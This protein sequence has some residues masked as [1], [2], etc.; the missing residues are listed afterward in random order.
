MSNKCEYFFNMAGWV[1]FLICSLFYI[2]NSIQADD[3]IY[4]AG[5]VIFLVACV[6]FM[7]PMIVNR[8]KYFK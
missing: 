7:V 4:L 2:Y 1:L 8:A 6:S 5:S 3:P